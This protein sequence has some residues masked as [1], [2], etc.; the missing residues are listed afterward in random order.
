M[1]INCRTDY[2]LQSVAMPTQGTTKKLFFN[3]TD[4]VD[5]CVKIRPQDVSAS[6]GSINYRS[7]VKNT[8]FLNCPDALCIRKGVM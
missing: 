8:D 3:Y 1:S 5:S 4:E 7:K 6:K 2:E